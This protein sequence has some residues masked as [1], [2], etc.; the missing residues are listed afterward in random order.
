MLFERKPMGVCLTQAGQ[1]LYRDS[2]DAFL[3]LSKS[4]E[5]A[6]PVAAEK[7][8]VLTTTPAFAAIWLIS[9][10]SRFH[11]LF[12][13][14]HIHVET[15]DVPVDLERD[16][17]VDLAIRCSAR[18]YPALF[19]LDLFTEYFGAYATPDFDDH[20]KNEKID[21]IAVQWNTPSPISVTWQ[22]WCA[23]AGKE[24]WLRRAVFRHYN[25]E[26]Y[27]LQA[28]LHGQG[29]VLASSV[30]VVDPLV[31]GALRP[32]EPSVRIPGARYLALCKPGRERL[33][34]IREFLEWLEEEAGK[35][36]LALARF[37]G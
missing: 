37:D 20:I 35:T 22:S 24:E 13:Q 1:R 25:D 27:A 19:Q 21:L 23:A 31:Q 30:L 5:A 11:E 17:G 7:T 9:R 28:V 16:S 34:P 32:I 6:R 18:D 36:R 2:H 10:L 3:R 14:L 12:P 15:S 4:L 29:A 26:H 33:T 8:L